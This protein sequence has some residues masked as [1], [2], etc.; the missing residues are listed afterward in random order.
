MAVSEWRLFHSSLTEKVKSRPVLEFRNL[1]IKEN[2]WHCVASEMNSM[3]TYSTHKITILVSLQLS[4]CCMLLTL[5]GGHKKM[6]VC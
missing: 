6:F 3:D 4:L 1:K 2:A 5:F